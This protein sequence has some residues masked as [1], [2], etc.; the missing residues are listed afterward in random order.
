MCFSAGASFGAATGLSIISLLS[1]HKASHTKKLMPLAASPLF[2][3]LQQACEGIVWITLNNGDNSS[4]LY[5]CAVYGFLFCACLWWPIWIPYALNAAET[6]YVRKK[7]LFIMQCI[8]II[9]GITLFISWVPYTTG[10]HII[11]HHI[12]YPVTNYPFNITNTLI[13]WLITG[14]I[15]TGYCVATIMP[16]FISS[17]AYIWIIGIATSIG[18]AASC[19][20]YYMALPSVWCFFAAISSVLLYFI[21]KKYHDNNI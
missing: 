8:G 14:I 6:V 12:D 20:F 4:I 11:N 3:A 19:I 17:I 7:L 10:A 18:L 16:F 21:I 5:W 9:S 15:A 13:S 1:L 2:F